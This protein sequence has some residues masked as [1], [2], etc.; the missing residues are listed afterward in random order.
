[1]SQSH[2]RRIALALVFCADAATPAAAFA[3][4]H[5]PTSI[6]YLVRDAKG[7][8]FDPAKLDSVSSP[9][10]EEMKPGKILFFN[11][12][13][14]VNREVKCLTSRVDHGGRPVLLSELTLN[15]NGKT[16]RLIFNTTV[17]EQRKQID[18]LPFRGDLQ[19]VRGQVGR[20]QGLTARPTRTRP[21]R[22][23]VRPSTVLRMRSTA[24]VVPSD[25]PKA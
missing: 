1:M 14:T 8:I 23:N 22:R 16:M 12:D 7:E 10:G 4:S 5:A 17:R 6:V 13:G 18:S 15:H 11:P 3:Q 19:V 20:G 25:R 9:K 24:R 2:A 21:A